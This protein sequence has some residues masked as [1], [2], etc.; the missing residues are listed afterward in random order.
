VAPLIYGGAVKTTENPPNND[1]NFKASLFNEIMPAVESDYK[2][3]HGPRA[4][5]I[6]GLSYGADL[7][8]RFALNNSDRFAYVGGFSPGGISDSSYPGVDGAKLNAAMKVIW[9][10]W[11]TSDSFVSESTPWKKWFRGKGIKYEEVLT[12]GTH[13]WP[14]WRKNLVEFAKQVF[15]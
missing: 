13:E 12:P 11:G 3:S 5:A 8:L 7:S 4:A 15:R 2:A 1:N 10:S 9:L 6:A 14:I